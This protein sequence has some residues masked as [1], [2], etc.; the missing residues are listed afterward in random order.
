MRSDGSYERESRSVVSNSATP[1]MVACQAPLSMEF[2][3]PHWSGLPFPSPGDLPHPD[4]LHCKQIL[5]HV[6]HQGG[7]QVGL[8]ST[9]ITCIHVRKEKRQRHET[10]GEN[11][12]WWQ[13][14]RLEGCSHKSRQAKN[15]GHHQKPERGEEGAYPAS[16]RVRGPAD[17]LICLQN[18]KRIPCWL[19]PPGWWCSVTVVVANEYNPYYTDGET[20]DQRGHRLKSHS[21]KVA[22]AKIVTSHEMPFPSAPWRHSN[23]WSLSDLSFQ[24]PCGGHSG[25]P[26]LAND[27]E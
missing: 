21:R 18:W 7:S 4:L 20:E 10:Q 1:W 5:C 26:Y 27:M 19:K 13:R 22:E 25:A 12:R 6:S 17:T 3:R 23:S 24:V 9:N 16:Q 8:K 14:Q 11:A 2:S 15:C